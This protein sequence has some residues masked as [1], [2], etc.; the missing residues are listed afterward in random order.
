MKFIYRITLENYQGET[1]F[2]LYHKEENAIKRFEELRLE[3]LSH[4]EYDYKNYI[5]VFSFF[6]NN[7]NEYSTFII[8]ERITEQQLFE[9]QGISP[10]LLLY[11]C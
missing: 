2:E 11:L 5:F 8:L 10:F 4:P 7:Y 9:D 6:D 3:A 1:T